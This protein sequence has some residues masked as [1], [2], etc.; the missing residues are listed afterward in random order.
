MTGRSTRIYTTTGLTAAVLV[1]AA[2]ASILAGTSHGT[3]RIWWIV[4]NL[5]GVATAVVAQAFE[6]R[7]RERQ[8]Q[9]V[10]TVA[11]DMRVAMNDALDP[12]VRQLGKIAVAGS[13]RTRDELREQTVPMVLYSAALLIGPDRVRACWFQL[14]DRAPR[15]LRPVLHE[16]RSGAP[17]TTFVEGTPSGDPVFELLTSNSHR[18]CKDVTTAP[19]RGWDPSHPHDYQTFLAV[20]VVAGSIAHGLLTVDSLEPGDLTEGDV[21]LLRLLAGLLADALAFGA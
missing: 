2:L 16:G 7:R 13:R 6:Q 17:R 20:P 12:I 1:I 9:A 19:P 4:V 15:A 5:A 10:E 11:I 21:P 3:A 14:D 8:R 18:F